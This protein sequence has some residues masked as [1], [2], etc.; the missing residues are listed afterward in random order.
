MFEGDFANMCA[1]RFPLMLMGD[2]EEGLAFSDPGVRTPISV[3]GNS[4]IKTI[5]IN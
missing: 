2:Q 1:K 4:F 5:Y 3:S